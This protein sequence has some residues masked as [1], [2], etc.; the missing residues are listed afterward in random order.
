MPKTCIIIG[1]S[2][3]A[4]ELAPSLR[5]EGWDGRILIIGDEPYLPYHRP[6]LS[7]AFLSGEKSVDDILIRP[8]AVYEKNNIEFMLNV[9]VASINRAENTI[10]LTSGE[11]LDY[12]KLA[13]ITIGLEQTIRDL[14]Q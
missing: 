7:K 2:H 9:R 5:Q 13:R 12:D 10:T 1:A 14:L 4:A 11:E 8:E 3:A 6:T